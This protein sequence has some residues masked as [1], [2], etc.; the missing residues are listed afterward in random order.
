MLMRVVFNIYQDPAENLPADLRERARQ[1]FVNT[2]KYAIEILTWQHCD[3]LPAGLQPAH[4]DN[5]Y[6][7]MLFNDE[8]HTYEQASVSF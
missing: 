5:T 1:I 6:A 3:G 4:M 8:V 2:V 7:T